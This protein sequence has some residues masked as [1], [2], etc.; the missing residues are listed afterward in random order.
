MFAN[1]ISWLNKKLEDTP[2]ETPEQIYN[3]L[4]DRSSMEISARLLSRAAFLES[5]GREA[6]RKFAVLD[7]I[8]AAQIER[9][10][11]LANPGKDIAPWRDLRDKFAE[12]LQNSSTQEHTNKEQ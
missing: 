9:L 2:Q 5:D 4:K 3:M 7:R 6:S 8:A 12:Q 10:V 11:G 1:V